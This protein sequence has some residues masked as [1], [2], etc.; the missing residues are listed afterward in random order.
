MIL[1]GAIFSTDPFHRDRDA[2]I[3]VQH[4][5][6][7]IMDNFGCILLVTGQ[8]IFFELLAEKISTY[9]TNM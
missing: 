4:V 9:H 8:V 1:G 6:R 5:N 2:N 3:H 7:Q